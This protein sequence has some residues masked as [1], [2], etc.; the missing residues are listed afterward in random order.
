MD[1][2]TGGDPADEELR[3]AIELLITT[4]EAQYASE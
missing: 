2:T 4:K 3:A 1:N